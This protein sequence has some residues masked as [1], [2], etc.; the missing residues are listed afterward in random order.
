MARTLPREAT[1]RKAG[2]AQTALPT[3]PR[4]AGG[5]DGSRADLAAIADSFIIILQLSSDLWIFSFGSS[6]V[7]DVSFMLARYPNHRFLFFSGIYHLAHDPRMSRPTG[8]SF[9][10]LFPVVELP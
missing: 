3:H 8:F 6:C 9:L 10:L 2:S 4:Q 7:L 1:V 5:R